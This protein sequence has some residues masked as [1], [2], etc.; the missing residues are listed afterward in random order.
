VVL[1]ISTDNLPTLSHW[2]K[3]ELKLTFPLASDFSQ[4]KVSEAYGV[5]NKDAGF[6]NRASF[7]VDPDGKIQHIEEGSSAVN[8]DGTALACSRLKKH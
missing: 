8:P 3:E 4:R 7:V 2:S 6:A 5:L 1:G